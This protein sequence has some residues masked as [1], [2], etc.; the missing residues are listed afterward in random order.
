MDKKPGL[1]F[2]EL[3]S[4]PITGLS[5]TRKP[6]WTDVGFGTDHYKI[7]LCLIGKNVIHEKSC[8]YSHLHTVREYLSFFEGVEN[9][10]IP[11]KQKYVLLKDYS[12]HKGASR[13]A[14]GAYIQYQKNNR[15]VAGIIYYNT[16]SFFSMV[17]KLAR[18]L[19][20]VNFPVEIV[21]DYEAAIT[22]AH[23][24]VAAD[25]Y[26]E[27]PKIDQ[28]LQSKTVSQIDLVTTDDDSICPVT[29]LPITNRRSW[30]DIKVDENYRV[31]FRLIGNAI[32]CTIPNGVPSDT[33][34]FNIIAERE[35]VLAEV[36][37]RGRKYAEI[38]DHSGIG[39]TP[40]KE[41]RLAVANLLVKELDDGNLLGFWVYKAPSF[42][43]WMFNV[44]ARLHKKSHA[45]GAVRDYEQAARN[46]LNVLRQNGVDVGRRQYRRVTKDDWRLDLK[47][48]RIS[49]E[50]IGNDIVYTIA[51]GAAEGSLCG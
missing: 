45:V 7:T 51:C 20:P 49:F 21:R 5:I 18:R 1:D 10:A 28:P 13:R 47:D 30:R 11:K 16:S 23:N 22:M 36:N 12:L 27:E 26:I 42:L 4:C 29:I 14:K 41:S 31:S 43:R 39:G 35:K 48:Y 19:N 15:R 44:G 2:G 3:T 17:I 9:E 8:G 40:S 33:G 46:A 6:E 25:L 32:L 37:L 50:L 34:T 38:R 24:T